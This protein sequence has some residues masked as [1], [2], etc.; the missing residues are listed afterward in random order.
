MRM[1]AAIRNI[2]I[3][4]GILGAAMLYWFAVDYIYAGNFELYHPYE[5]LVELSFLLFVLI[6]FNYNYKSL[7]IPAEK[8]RLFVALLIPVM[9][10]FL[11]LVVIHYFGIDMH[12]L[13]GYL[14]FREYAAR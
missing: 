5:T 3:N 7:G 4:L 1:L 2:S 10:S 12:V 11:F 13:V 8:T 9:L 14:L 6:A